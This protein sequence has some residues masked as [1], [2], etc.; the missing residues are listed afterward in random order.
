MTL[1]IAKNFYRINRKIVCF[2]KTFLA[3]PSKDTLLTAVAQDGNE[4]LVLVAF[5]IV[6]SKNS[7]SWNWFIEK[8]NNEFNL[9]TEETVIIS[10]RDKGIVQAFSNIL[11]C[12]KKI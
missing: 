1:A 7:S 8:I 5:S 12:S 4:S 3:G 2:D 6:E 10:E 11:P 9:N